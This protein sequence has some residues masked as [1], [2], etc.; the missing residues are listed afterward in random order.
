MKI[1]WLKPLIGHDGPFTSVYID[2]TRADEAGEREVENRWKGLRRI[3]EREGAPEAILEEIGERLARP[4]HVAG[5]HGR[6]VVAAHGEIVLDKL[7]SNPPV[8]E[9]ASHGPLPCLLP[10]AHAADQS[11]ARLVVEVNREG[12]DLTYVESARALGGSLEKIRTAV[13]GGHDVISK[14]HAG[15]WSH[16]RFESRAEDSW[17]RNAEAVAAEIDSV[18]IESTPEVVILTGD[19]R[20][21]AL[22]RGALAKR[23]ADLAIEVPGGSRNDG[24]KDDVFRDRLDEALDRFR[25]GRRSV[26]LDHFRQEHGRDGAATSSLDDVV[27]VLQRGQVA[28]LIFDE[29]EAITA[30]RLGDR[31][32]WVGEELLQ[33]GTSR[34]QLDDIGAGSSAREMTAD[35]ALV[36][37]ALGQDAGITFAPA[38]SVDLPDGVGAVLR[39]H[40]QSTPSEGAPS[41]SS[42]TERLHDVG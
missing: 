8:R 37:A 18:V 27:T 22:V 9:S 38:G 36:R 29:S 15:G 20:A 17:E 10:A 7:L 6:F 28:E 41:L 30:D 39:W 2:A 42:D 25:E 23:S 16:R 11:V 24:V 3:L 40:D 19:V 5:P 34:A 4:T 12:A 14:A 1:D 21:V 35:V 26:V 31:Q 32:L 33:I 13:S